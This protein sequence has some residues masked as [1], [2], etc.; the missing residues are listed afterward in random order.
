VDADCWGP[1]RGRGC[2]RRQWSQLYEPALPPMV[3][4]RC[5]RRWTAR[6]EPPPRWPRSLGQFG[7]KWI[8]WREWGG[9]SCF[10]G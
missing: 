8:G 10:S 7:V 2:R 6:K 9:T 5:S 1:G 4:I 3:K